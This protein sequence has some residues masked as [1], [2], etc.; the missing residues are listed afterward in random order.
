MLFV[1][2]DVTKDNEF[3][4][5]ITFIPLQTKRLSKLLTLCILME[6][7]INMN[8]LRMRLPMYFKGSQ[9]E[10]LNYGIFLSLNVVLI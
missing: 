8:T 6:F 2:C 7:P 9:V 3:K 1:K 5:F 4:G 10:F